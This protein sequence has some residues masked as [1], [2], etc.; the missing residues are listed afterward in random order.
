MFLHEIDHLSVTILMD[1]YTDR[2]LPTSLPAI[3]PP[4]VMH[5]RFLPAPIAEHGFSTIIDIRYNDD[6]KKYLADPV[7]VYYI[8]FH[9]SKLVLKIKNK[10]TTKTQRTQRS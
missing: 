1:N 5:G 4:M 9:Y 10:F 6:N 7:L 2:L 8:I 3:R